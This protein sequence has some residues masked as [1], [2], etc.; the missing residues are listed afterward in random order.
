MIMKETKQNKKNPRVFQRFVNIYIYLFI[1][2]YIVS[3]AVN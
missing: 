1:Y 3:W 2:V